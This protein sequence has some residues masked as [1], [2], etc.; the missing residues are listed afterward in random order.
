MFCCIKKSSQLFFLPSYNH[1]TM[2]FTFHN[3]IFRE[4]LTQ[5]WHIG[6]INLHQYHCVCRCSKPQCFPVIFSSVWD[7]SSLGAHKPHAHVL[8]MHP[9]IMHM[10]F[11]CSTC[12]CWNEVSGV[13]TADLVDSWPLSD[14]HTEREQWHQFSQKE[15]RWVADAWKDNKGLKLFPHWEQISQQSWL[16]LM[17]W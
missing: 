11:Q 12:F 5:K 14:Q 8:S 9:N 17:L 2:P 7:Y 4:L 10:V 16:Y 1:M 15:Q 13:R 3:T 6:Y